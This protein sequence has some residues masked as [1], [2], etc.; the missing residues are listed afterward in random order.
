MK[1]PDFFPELF[2]D[3]C[4]N[5]IKNSSKNCFIVFFRNSL[6]LSSLKSSTDSSQLEI[7]FLLKILIRFLPGLFPD[8]F[9]RIFFSGIILTFSPG[10]LKKIIFENFSEC[11]CKVLLKISYNLFQRFLICLLFRIFFPHFYIYFLLKV[12]GDFFFW[13]LPWTISE[14]PSKSAPVTF[15]Y[16]FERRSCNFPGF[17]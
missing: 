15:P 12:R 3:S 1:F 11:S 7:V 4:Q 6:R 13:I 5:L 8:I 16:F 2:W 10:I 14:L 9:S 17:F